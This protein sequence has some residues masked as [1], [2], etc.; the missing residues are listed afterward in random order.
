MKDVDGLDATREIKAIFP[1]ARVVIVSHWDSP[2]LR[3]KARQVGA[4]SFVTKTN[5]LPLRDLFE[6]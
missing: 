6:S 2:A 1:D 5:L 4:T 3:K